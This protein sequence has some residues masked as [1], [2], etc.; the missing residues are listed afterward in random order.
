MS[1]RDKI[2]LDRIAAKLCPICGESK[3]EADLK[4]I[5]DPK[6]GLVTICAKHPCEGVENVL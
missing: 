1:E 5:Q 6:F 4:L 2:I 3:V